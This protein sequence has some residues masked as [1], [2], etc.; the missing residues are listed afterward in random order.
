MERW[1]SASTFTAVLPSQGAYLQ[2]GD[3]GDFDK[4]VALRREIAHAHGEHLRL[5]LIHEIGTMAL[6]DRLTDT[7]HKATRH[8]SSGSC[9]NAIMA[10]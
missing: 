8:I 7:T 9:E 10:N 2:F 6:A 3:V 1:S 5:F 4:G